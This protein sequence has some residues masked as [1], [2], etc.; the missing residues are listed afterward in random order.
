MSYFKHL[1][2][3]FVVVLLLNNNTKSQVV[4]ARAEDFQ[5]IC[6]R[7]LIVQLIVEDAYFVEDLQKRISK[8]SNAKRK[9]E[10]ESELSAYREFVS[11]YNSQIKE[12]IAKD[13]QFN[14]EKNIEF[15]TFSEV[16]ELRKANPKSYTLLQFVQTKLW[17]TNEYGIQTFTKKTI[18][19]MV[20]SRMEN[21]EPYDEDFNKKIDYSFYM[22]FIN[23]RKNHQ[24]YG[25]DLLI[26][27]KIIQNHIKEI[28]NFDKKNY[29]ITDYA[30]DQDDEN[31]IKLKNMALIVDE[32]LIDA[33]TKKTDISKAFTGK[34]NIVS[35]E[36]ISKIID[37]Q[38]EEAVSIS[39]PIT[40]KSDKS[41]IAGL[42]YMEEVMYMKCFVNAKSGIFYATYISKTGGNWEPFFKTQEFKRIEKCK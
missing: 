40:I 10:L 25:S 26:S 20:Y 31:C 28:R 1:L 7:Q 33:K 3:L 17:V 19:T 27:L 22:P 30:K 12:A 38:E 8:T 6:N 37:N 5:G 42:E 2:L 34:I 16:Q 41:G 36:E 11:A 21:C 9:E 39:L 18:P 15:K 35:S 24:L 32:K 23:S 4:N 14:K 13:W 29:T